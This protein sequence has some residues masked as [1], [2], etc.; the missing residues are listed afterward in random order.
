PGGVRTRFRAGA[1]PIREELDWDGWIGVSEP[2]PF[3]ATVYHPGNWRK[4]QGYGNGTLGDMGCHIFSTPLGGL[5]V[6]P[7]RRHGIPPLLAPPARPRSRTAPAGFVS[8]TCA[9]LR[10]LAGAVEDSF[11][12]RR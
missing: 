11:R 7:P 2:R 12:V 5:G 6:R 10:P 3:K 4:R 1:D 9:V 8:R